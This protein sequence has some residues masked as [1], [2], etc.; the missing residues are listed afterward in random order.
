LPS[1]TSPATDKLPCFLKVG[2]TFRIAE[3]RRSGR[4]YFHDRT[5][6]FSPV[7]YRPRDG[8]SWPGLFTLDGAISVL[9]ALPL[10]AIQSL[11]SMLLKSFATS[12]AVCFLGCVVGVA[13]V[14]SDA[15]RLPSFIWP[16]AIN[17]RALNLGSTALA[18]SGG[19][20]VQ[21]ALLIVG[22]ALGFAF[23]V[24]GLTVAAIRTVKL[25]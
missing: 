8:P 6:F 11:L 24:V 13:T 22:I 10:I 19:L 16:Q 17:I 18:G 21:D 1:L 25:R 14:T 3:P 12:V 5:A 20:T 2:N 4:R 9:A 15:L 23:I 7:D